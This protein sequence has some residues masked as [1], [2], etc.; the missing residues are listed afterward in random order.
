[1]DYSEEDTL[2]M[3]AEIMEGIKRNLPPLSGTTD[4]LEVKYTKG[5]LLYT[6]RC[7]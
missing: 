1:M 6:S 7:V 4:S 2:Y 3:S 5:C